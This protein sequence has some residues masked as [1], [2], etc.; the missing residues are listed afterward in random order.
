[1][2]LTDFGTLSA[3]QKRVWAAELWQAGRDASFFFANGFIG[4]SDSETNAVIQRVNKLTDTERGS[5]CVMQ[6]VQDLQNDGIVGDNTL[7]GNE[8]AMANDSVSIRLDQIRHG[9]K[10]KGL[11]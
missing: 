1:M 7:T 2:A 5:E 10:S 6:L 8:E 11:H 4:G 9:V 3:A